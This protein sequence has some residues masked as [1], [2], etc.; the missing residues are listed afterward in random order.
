MRITNAQ[1][2]AI[3]SHSMNTN[4]GRL[5]KLMQQM[6]SN[7][8]IQLPSDDPVASVRI[9]RI[10]REE[11]SLTQYTT[12][13]DNVSS[14]MS[15]QEA[16]LTS[17]SDTML[18]TRDLLL[19]AANT[20]ANSDAD[21]AAIAGEL[22]SLENTILSFIN[23]RDE[24]GRYLFSGT[25]SDT[26]TVT[27]DAAT[28]T[29]AV[30]GNANHR[31][32]AVANGVLVPQNVTAAEIFGGNVDI[33]NELHALVKQLKDPALD[34]TDPAVR[35]QIST[36]INQLDVAQGGI[37]G[38]ITELGG[39]QNTLSLLRGSNEQV[40]LVNQK[41]EGDLS[42]LDYSVATVDLSNY[43]LALQASQKTYMKINELSLFGL[44]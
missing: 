11:A 37:L 39:R 31:Q 15:I 43:Q 17:M 25:L 1:I 9:L 24:E 41:I 27:F 40:S 36:T 7:K 29:Y 6:A 42:L 19:W 33:L 38:A 26:Q 44:S 16:N 34:A 2:N 28:E 30:T 8:R 12:N 3:M 4:T 18:N 10:Q 23:V 32:I 21:L 14:S 13:I 22:E 5:A 35:A 20:G